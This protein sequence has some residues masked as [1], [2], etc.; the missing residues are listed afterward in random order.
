MGVPEVV[1]GRHV[2]GPA[3]DRLL[4]RRRGEPFWIPV[5]QED[6]LEVGLG[7]PEELQAVFLRAAQGLLVGLG[8]AP[9]EVEKGDQALTGEGLSNCGCRFSVPG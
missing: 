1:L 9:R 6:V 3:G 5:Q 7:R 4:H 2:R 8:P